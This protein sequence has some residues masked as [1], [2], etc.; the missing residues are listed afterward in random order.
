MKLF[1]RGT[2]TLAVAAIAP[3]MA[4][5]LALPATSAYVLNE[6]SGT[7]SVADLATD[8]LAGTL[9][10]DVKQYGLVVGDD[11]NALNMSDQSSNILIVNSE[12]QAEAERLMSQEPPEGNGRSGLVSVSDTDSR[13]MTKEISV[14]DRHGT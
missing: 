10:T 11:G 13:Q 1:I 7:E 2:L 14:G 6:K 9:K 3:M 8:T 4:A 12:K 5:G